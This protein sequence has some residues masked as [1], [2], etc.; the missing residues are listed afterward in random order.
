MHLMVRLVDRFLVL[1]HGKVLAE[2]TPEEIIQDR[3]VV[4][5]YLGKKWSAA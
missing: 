1:D 3:S 2:G 4:A 5:A